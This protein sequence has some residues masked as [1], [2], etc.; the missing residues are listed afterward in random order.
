MTREKRP[1]TLAEL[2]QCLENPWWLLNNLMSIK[3]K[4]GGVVKFRPNAVQRAIYKSYWWLNNILKSRQHGVSTFWVLFF[5][6][7]LLNE[8]DKVAGVIDITENDAKKKLGMAKT[9]YENLDNPLVHDEEWE[10]TGPDGK[11]MMVAMWQIGKQLKDAVKMT[12]GREAPFPQ[13]IVFSNGSS[14]YAGVS[15]RGGTLQ[16]GLFTEFGK[17]SVKDPT[18]AAEIV[19]GAENAMHEGSIGVFE[20]T[21][22]GGQSGLA[23]ER[24]VTAMKN[25]RDNDQLTRL[26]QKFMFFGWFLDPANCLNDGQAALILD[27]LEGTSKVETRSGPWEWHSYFYGGYSITGQKLEGIV[28]RLKQEGQHLSKGQIAW[29][30]NK[31]ISQGWAML[32]EHPTFPEEAFQAPIQGAI[33]AEAILRAESEERVA[34]FQPH[35]GKL[36]HTIHDIGSNRNWVTWYVQRV[37]AQYWVID[38]DHDLPVD[39]TIG[40]RVGIMQSKG[41]N[42]GCCVL[43]H[44]S[45][46]DK[47]GNIS[48]VDVMRQAGMQNVRPLPKTQDRTLR[49]DGLHSLLPNFHFRESTTKKGREML[50]LYRY[51]TDAKTDHVTDIIATGEANHYADSLGYIWEAEEAG[52]FQEENYQARKGPAVQRASVGVGNL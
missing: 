5:L 13:E 18:K 4:A 19:E 9:S 40:E 38:C 1:R 33:Y 48:T 8:R 26:D 36:V 31:R 51:K 6:V 20:T 30:I 34:E 45:E 16:Y 23:Y 37:G 17:I 29:Y 28:E 41:Y 49:I 14:F 46:H 15:F 39:L 24:C 42:L 47:I 32:K 7:R 25:P 3:P 44:D 27:R 43:P 11:V 50:K 2:K 52:F 10:M 22:E 21:M 35:K 12:K